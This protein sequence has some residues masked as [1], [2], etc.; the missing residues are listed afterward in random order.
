M[1]TIEGLL[2]AVLVLGWILS[3]VFVAGIA[4]KTRG[5]G[6]MFRWFLAAALFSPPIALLAL[7]VIVLDAGLERLKEERPGAPR[8]G[9]PPTRGRFSEL[10]GD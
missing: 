10:A 1:G 2:L 8:L 4:A 7:G 5:V 6:S 3:S 9:E